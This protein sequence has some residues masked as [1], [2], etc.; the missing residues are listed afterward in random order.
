MEEDLENLQ[1]GNENIDTDNAPEAPEEQVE[2]EQNWYETDYY[3]SPETYD[4]KD[5]QLPDGMKLNEEMTAKFNDFA[6]KTNMSQKSANECMQL[7]VEHTNSIFKQVAEANNFVREENIQ[8]WDKLCDADDT[9]K[10]QK[11]DE[12]VNIAN[13]AMEKLI[14]ADSDFKEELKKTG[15]NHHP[16]LIKAFRQLGEFMLPTEIKRASSSPKEK[17]TAEIFYPEMYKDE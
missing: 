2:Q 4:Y 8:K 7:A 12:A 17:S 11:Y 15:L 14:P 13:M 9:L 10:G 6:K 1:D 3:G 16:V 5:V